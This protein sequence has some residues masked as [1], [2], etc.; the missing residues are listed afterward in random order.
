MSKGEASEY[1]LGTDD[2]EL[3]RLHEQHEVWVAALRALLGEVRLAPGAAVLDLGC[4]P[5]YTSFELARAVGPRGHVLA[6]DVSARFIAWLTAERDRRE[7]P[8]VEPSLGPVEALSL[9]PASLDAVYARWVLCWLADPGA[10]LQRVAAALKPGGLVLL[11]EYL[12]WG[13]F[14]LIPRGPATDAAVQACL[15]SWA[16][17]PGKIDIAEELPTLAARCGLR[18]ESLRPIARLG[19]VGSGEWR[20]LGGFLESY[21]PRL[22]ERGLLTAAAL[23]AWELEWQEREATAEVAGQCSDPGRVATPQ[24]FIACPTMADIVLRRA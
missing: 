3:R 19:A 2:V 18:V 10:V 9:T 22:V 4:G 5:G 1:V 23:Q 16:D 20:W 17:G 15:T 12:D 11:Q 7:L 21:L 6:R 8:Q 13:T 24:T 14:R